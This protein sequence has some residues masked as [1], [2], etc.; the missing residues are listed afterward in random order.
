M[1]APPRR[2]V[3]VRGADPGLVRLA[4]ERLAAEERV[5]PVLEVPSGRTSPDL[6]GVLVVGDDPRP[7]D[8]RPHS[9]LAV[10]AFSTAVGARVDVP[11]AVARDVTVCVGRVSESAMTADRAVA[12]MLAALR[13]VFR[14]DALVRSGGWRP[15]RLARDLHGA[16]VGL[17]GEGDAVRE[18]VKRLSGFG[19]RV[20]LLTEAAPGDPSAHPELDVLVVLPGA[21]AAE[22][23]PDAPVQVWLTAEAGAVYT[24]QTSTEPITTP[25]PGDHR[26]RVRAEADL[27]RSIADLVRLAAV[28][29]PASQDVG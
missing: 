3:L 26:D 9:R 22:D 20:L 11:A 8:L 13:D 28:G 7:V 29:A 14:V 27:R 18:T 12:L 1:N 23:L 15:R 5:Q 25:P 17:V 16:T 19:C 2:L 24:T 4:V 21:T 6:W 10:V